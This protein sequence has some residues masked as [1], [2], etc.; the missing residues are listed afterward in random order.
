MVYLL[1]CNL[2]ELLVVAITSVAALGQPHLDP[3]PQ[4]QRRAVDPGPDGGVVEVHLT[5]PAFAVHL[6][7]HTAEALPYPR[8]EER[9]L[10]ISPAHVGPGAH[11][12]AHSAFRSE[13]QVGNAIGDGDATGDPLAAQHMRGVLAGADDFDGSTAI[14]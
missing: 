8:L 13:I 12:A 7:H 2:S 4:R 9:G 3:L 6:D 1:S 10:D 11:D 14:R 5:P